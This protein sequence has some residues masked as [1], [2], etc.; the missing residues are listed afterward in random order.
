MKAPV[1][2]DE[3]Y[4]T[5]RAALLGGPAPRVLARRLLLPALRG[6]QG[7]PA[8]G[9]GPVAVC[10]L[11]LPGLAYG[12]HPLP[13]H[14]VAAAQWF[15]AMFF[16]ARHK[17]GISALQFQ[18]DAGL[19]SYKTAWVLLHK[20]RSSQYVRDIV[21]EFKINED[22]TEETFHRY[23]RIIRNSLHQCSSGPRKRCSCARP[24]AP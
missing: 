10:G 2:L 14:A 24:I 11:P 4:R 16:I 8:A 3:F 22:R 18:R 23:R 13:R 9:A 21:R 6:A 7:A 12:R 17:G 20:V 19:G 5:F 1:T 15:L